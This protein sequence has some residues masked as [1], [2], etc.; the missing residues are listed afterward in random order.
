M[1][2]VFLIKETVVNQS[3]KV[4]KGKGVKFYKTTD[5]RFKLKNYFFNLTFSIR[6]FLES[7]IWVEIPLLVAFKIIVI[8]SS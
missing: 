4:L 1:Q 3:N 8:Y 2:P 6:M 5:P 7:S